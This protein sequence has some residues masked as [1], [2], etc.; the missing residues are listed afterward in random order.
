MNN[1]SVDYSQKVVEMKNITKKFGN[2]VAND[3]INLTVHKGEV[4]ALLGENGA[5][6]STL[7]NRLYG[8]YNPTSGEIY[9]NGELTAIEATKLAK[10]AST[11]SAYDL[12]QATK[13]INKVGETETEV[14]CFI[15]YGGSATELVK[16]YNV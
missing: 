3:N 8:L 1:N 2:F 5:G 9:I 15:L 10:V 11:A 16:N 6:K 4:H 12:S 14:D 13:D 7:M